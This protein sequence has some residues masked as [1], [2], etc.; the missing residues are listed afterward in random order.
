M[1]YGRQVNGGKSFQQLF[2]VDLYVNQGDIEAVIME[3]LC[4]VLI[5]G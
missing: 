3:E 5:L 2:M 1:E 4:Q